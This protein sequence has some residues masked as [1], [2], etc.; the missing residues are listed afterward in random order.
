MIL[1]C[2]NNATKSLNIVLGTSGGFL[3]LGGAVPPSFLLASANKLALFSN[4]SEVLVS[5]IALKH[6][7][8]R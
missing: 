2:G 3:R 6:T 7:A 8:E 4:S 5:P 1:S